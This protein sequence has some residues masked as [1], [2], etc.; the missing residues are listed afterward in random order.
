MDDITASK[1]LASVKFLQDI[2]NHAVYDTKHLKLEKKISNGSNQPIWRLSDECREYKKCSNVRVHYACITCGQDASVKMNLFYRKLNRNSQGCH[3]C[4]N[5][6]VQKVANHKAKFAAGLFKSKADRIKLVYTPEEMV[7]RSLTEFEQEDSDFKQYYFQKYLT[8]E[9]FDRVKPKISSVN[10]RTDLINL[11]Y[12]PVL[13]VNNQYKFYPALRDTVTNH[14]LK[15]HH[16]KF[17]C[18]SCT[19]IFPVKSLESQKNKFKVLCRE[20]SLSNNIFKIREY[21]MR[22]GTIRYQ[23]KLELRFVKHLDEANVQVKNGPRVPYL[24]NGTSHTYVIDF[25]LPEHGLLV[26]M[27]DN[28]IWHKRQIENGKWAAKEEAAMA[29]AKTQA[30]KYVILY[31]DTYL[32]FLKVEVK[33]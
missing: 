4:C 16:V 30:L 1:L 13:K 18:E 10:D 23:S 5:Y 26:E 11:E 15:A 6:D 22:Q 9:E 3:T 12:L 29:Y 14:I 28:H 21:K 31:P 24:W 33:I 19:G 20:C 27:K 7:Q 17:V 8:I 25:Y 2:G 32:N